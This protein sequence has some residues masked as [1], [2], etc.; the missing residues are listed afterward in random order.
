MHLLGHNKRLCFYQNK[1]SILKNSCFPKLK[2]NVVLRLPLFCFMHTQ[3]ASY[4]SRFCKTAQATNNGN[5][6]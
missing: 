2:R 5:G 1:S 6:V 4:L 3:L